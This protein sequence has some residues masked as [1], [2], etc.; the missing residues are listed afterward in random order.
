MT[1]TVSAIKA[2]RKE[3]DKICQ[4]VTTLTKSKME[5]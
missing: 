2:F 5:S 3:I 4:F 1:E